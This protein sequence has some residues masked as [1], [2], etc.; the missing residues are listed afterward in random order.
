MYFVVSS[1]AYIIIHLTIIRLDVVFTQNFLTIFNSKGIL[2]SL[3]FFV[4]LKANNFKLY[5]SD[6]NFSNI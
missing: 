2:F 5:V 6:S 4:L 3:N 1:Q